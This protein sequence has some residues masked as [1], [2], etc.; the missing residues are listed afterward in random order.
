MCDNNPC[1]YGLKPPITSP[2]HH[3]QNDDNTTADQGNQA[4]KTL[5]RERMF[6]IKPLPTHLAKV[7]NVEQKPAI[8]IYMGIKKYDSSPLSDSYKL[9]QKNSPILYTILF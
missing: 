8:M 4:H 9:T 1:G 7:V 3:H 6:K 2:S 5:Q